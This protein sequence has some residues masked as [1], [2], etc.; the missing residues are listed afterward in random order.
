MHD[1]CIHHAESLSKAALKGAGMRWVMFT[2]LVSIAV[3]AVGFVRS[4][5]RQNRLDVGAVSDDW[6][7]QHRAKT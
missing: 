4:R 5:N 3:G 2:V 1:S 6:I 7:A